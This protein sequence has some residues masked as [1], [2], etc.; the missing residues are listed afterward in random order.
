MLIRAKRPARELRSVSCIDAAHHPRRHASVSITGSPLHRLYFLFCTTQPLTPFRKYFRGRSGTRE[1]PKSQWPD[2]TPTK[3]RPLGGL[4]FL[5]GSSYI[6]ATTQ[7]FAWLAAHLTHPLHTLPQ[8]SAEPRVPEGRI[9][10][11]IT[12]RIIKPIDRK[13]IGKEEP[14]CR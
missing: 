5:F 14:L 7:G 12:H 6:R 8:A 1:R 11:S 13:R 4:S 9:T 10:A 3:M 2:A